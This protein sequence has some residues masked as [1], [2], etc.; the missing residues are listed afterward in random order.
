MVE[1]GK[2]LRNRI[3]ATLISRRATSTSLSHYLS[4]DVI[5]ITDDNKLCTLIRQM[6]LRIYRV[7]GLSCYNSPIL[8]F[9][10]NK[11]KAYK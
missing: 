8:L 2:L 3:S 5:T 7:Y 4:L 1:V 11:I 9:H 6:L 10:N